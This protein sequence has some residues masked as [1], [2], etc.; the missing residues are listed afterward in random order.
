M[1]KRF[2]R[3]EEGGIAVEAV[4]IFPM[5]TWAYLATFVYFDAFRSQSTALKAAF[6]ISDA[7]SREGDDYITN[8]YI[9]SLWRIQRFL[10]SS[11][12]RPKM[13]ITV[14]SYDPD[15]DEYEV[16]WSVNK[17]GMGNLNDTKLNALSDQLPVMHE[18][19]VAILV[20]TEVVYEPVFS[21]GLEAFVFEN[22]VVT[23][24]RFYPSQ[25]CYSRDGFDDDAIC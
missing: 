3:E 2:H 20:Q 22:L 4:L 9:T 15:Q 21:I 11:N 7:I 18:T 14:M 24:P 6:T 12:H 5:L 1:I 13:R 25:M 17:G 23:R 16:H 8:A 19:E 10:T